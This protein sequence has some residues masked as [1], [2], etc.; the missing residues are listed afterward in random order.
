MAKKEPKAVKVKKTAPKPL[1]E[2]PNDLRAL[3]TVLKRFIKE[4]L[5]GFKVDDS[6]KGDFSTSYGT[7]SRLHQQE[8]S[9]MEE[10]HQKA[11]NDPRYKQIV[12]ARLEYQNKLQD[13]KDAYDSLM[14]SFQLEMP[15]IAT[16]DQAKEFLQRVRLHHNMVSQYRQ[17]AEE[18]RR[19]NHPSMEP[20]GMLW[21]ED[22]LKDQEKAKAETISEDKAVEM[23]KGVGVEIEVMDDCPPADGTAE[24]P[25]DETPFDDSSRLVEDEVKALLGNE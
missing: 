6:W 7:L 15:F 10:Y 3:A 2:Q 5:G 9:L 4:G 24:C 1:V 14:E 13:A 18:L 11:K 22:Y 17:K 25:E 23:L 21:Y 19:Y 20:A 8:D 16:E 12:A